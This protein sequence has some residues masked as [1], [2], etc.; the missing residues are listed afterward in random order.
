MSICA[1]ECRDA[2]AMLV[3]YASGSTA[4]SGIVF[5]WARTLWGRIKNDAHIHTR[6]YIADTWE[7]V[8]QTDENF[9]VPYV[10]QKCTYMNL[11]LVSRRSVESCHKTNAICPTAGT[12]II[13]HSSISRTM[14]HL[15]YLVFFCVTGFTVFLT[16]W[17]KIVIK[18]QQI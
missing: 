17:Q 4:C 1:D 8:R 5:V 14:V 11:F 3:N 16:S 12:S 10:T 13:C 2:A 6:L 15:C 7:D 9:G 18:L